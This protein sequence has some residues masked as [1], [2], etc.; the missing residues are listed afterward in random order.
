MRDKPVLR[1]R[2]SARMSQTSTKDTY[3][4]SCAINGTLFAFGEIVTTS[5]GCRAALGL[6]TKSGWPGCFVE[7][8]RLLKH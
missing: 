4:P 5:A 8:S 7:P 2:K 1:F 3:Y 6:K